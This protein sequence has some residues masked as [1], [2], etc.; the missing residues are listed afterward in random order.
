[1]KKLAVLVPCFNEEEVLP[2]FYREAIRVLK[3]VPYDYEI[4][5]INDGSGDGT[6]QVIRQISEED[7]HV[8]YI[9]FS[10]N[11]G[12]EAA[13]YAALSNTDADYSVIMDADLQQPPAILP[14]MLS[15]LETGDYD[16]V[17]AVRSRRDGES[18]VNSWFSGHFYG[19]MNRLSETQLIEDA[20]DFRMMTREVVQ[21]MTAMTE[22]GRFTKG[23]FSWVGF[24]TYCLPYECADRAAGSSKWNFGKLLR[25]GIDGIVNFSSAPLRIA[26]P[27]GIICFLCGIVFLI[28][29]IVRSVSMG[30]P[31]VDNWFIASLIMLTG[32]M[33]LIAA[34]INGR[35][36]NAVFRESKHRPHYIVADSNI[37]GIRRIN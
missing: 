9:T 8:R 12:K 7:A 36:L 24:R 13:M 34:G 22:E 4:L 19:L 5:F 37:D 33:N 20:S 14:E 1:M 18:R 17:A 25:Y 21:A 2:L 6:A 28:T 35:Y 11:F 16:V 23:L 30:L 31:F 32:G 27:A 29:A 15:I 26:A 3:S 10:R